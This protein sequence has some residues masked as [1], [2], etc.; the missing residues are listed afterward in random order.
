[1]LVSYPRVN[2]GKIWIGNVRLMLLIYVKGNQKG[3]GVFMWSTDSLWDL[4][5]NAKYPF[6]SEKPVNAPLADT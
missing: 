1:M 5:S 6:G 3:I 2:R 4:I